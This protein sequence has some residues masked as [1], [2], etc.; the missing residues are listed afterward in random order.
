MIISLFWIVVIAIIVVSI[1]SVLLLAVISDG[2]E[3]DLSGYGMIILI[4]AP[5][6]IFGMFLGRWLT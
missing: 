3:R 1:I 2:L 4:G 5:F 6:L